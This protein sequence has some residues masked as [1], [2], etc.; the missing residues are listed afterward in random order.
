MVD[1]EGNFSLASSSIYS[2]YLS[3]RPQ[4]SFLLFYDTIGIEVLF[5]AGP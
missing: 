1:G 4:V 5:V 3:L 2:K